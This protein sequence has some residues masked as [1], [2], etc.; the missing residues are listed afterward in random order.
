ML[1]HYKELIM[2]SIKVNSPR[3]DDSQ[4]HSI[5]TM[6]ESERKNNIRFELL[7][8]TRELVNEEY[9]DNRANAHNAWVAANIAAKAGGRKP[10]PYP[11]P[12]AYP[13]YLD[14]LRKATELTKF[15]ELGEGLPHSV[16]KET[17][18]AAFNRYVKH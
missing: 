16:E 1:T 14:I 18:V 13:T 2:S 12:V 6:I 15:V 3:D 4:A 17:L 10:I 8:M 5:A 11:L 9:I 7:K